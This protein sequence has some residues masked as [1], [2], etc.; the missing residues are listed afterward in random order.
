MNHFIFRS[1]LLVAILLLGAFFR[2][3]NSNWDQNFHLHPD[4]RFLTMVGNAMKMPQSIGDYFN[5]ATSLFNP[6]NIGFSFY[7]YGILPLILNLLISLFLNHANYTD[8]TLQGRM[9]SAIADIIIIFLVYKSAQLFEKRYELPHSF[10][11]VAAFFYTIAILPIQLSHFFTVDMFLTLFAFASFYFACRFALHHSWINLL[12][13]AVFLGFALAS[14]ISA[15]FIA[16][17]IMFTTQLSFLTLR[18]IKL[19]FISSQSTSRLRRQIAQI[20]YMLFSII[21]F[22]GIVYLILRI[23]D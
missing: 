8:F 15:I 6:A 23:S 17:F 5:P 20:G 22:L 7:V 2:L 1:C 19:P 12:F 10:P 3:Y 18:E 16:P 21:F 11:Y 9:L 14:K 13:S 4:E